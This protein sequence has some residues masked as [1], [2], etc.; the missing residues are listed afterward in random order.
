MGE[1]QHACLYSSKSVRRLSSRSIGIHRKAF[2]LQP[3]PRKEA[4]TGI[5][6]IAPTG[7][8]EHE[9][10]SCGDQSQ[11]SCDRGWS[12]SVHCLQMGLGSLASL[13]IGAMVVEQVGVWCCFIQDL[14]SHPSRS[15]IQMCCTST[16]YHALACRWDPTDGCT[17][18][19]NDHN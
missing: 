4:S 16:V 18:R 5:A 10:A 17:S 15:P 1:C 8:G 13:T 2:R 7:V 3:S 19:K 14:A 11:M 9:V 12:I 6:E